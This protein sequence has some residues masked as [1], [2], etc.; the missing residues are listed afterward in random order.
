MLFFS[1][2][3]ILLLETWKI[4][5]HGPVAI[6]KI[7]MT[8]MFSLYDTV[9]FWSC[10]YAIEYCGYWLRSNFYAAETSFVVRWTQHCLENE[11]CSLVNALSACMV[12]SFRIVVLW[13]TQ[14]RIVLVMGWKTYSLE[15]SLS[16]W[17]QLNSKIVELH[18]RLG[19]ASFVLFKLLNWTTL[20]PGAHASL[21]DHKKYS[22]LKFSVQQQ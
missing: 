15:L 5:I 18:D 10:E 19:S 21:F 9:C 4:L 11:Q 14:S 2:Y 16:C 17:H 12:G 20:L 8:E 13:A 7:V 3:T 22:V 1:C 6:S